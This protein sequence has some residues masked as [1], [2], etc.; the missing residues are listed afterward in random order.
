MILWRPF[1]FKPLHPRYCAM[2]KEIGELILLI[3][4]ETT[5][6]FKKKEVSG[7]IYPI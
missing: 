6:M 1:S 4:D 2:L 5:M 3:E 7:V